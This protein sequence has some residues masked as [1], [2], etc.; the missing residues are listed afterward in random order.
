MKTNNQLAE[1]FAEI[2]IRKMEEMKSEKWEKPWFDVGGK[3]NFYPQN[4][5]GRKY[6]SG[7]AFLLLLAC[8]WE[9]YK[10]PLFL[11]FNQCRELEISI[12]KNEKSFPIYYKNFLVYH[13]ENNK[14]INIDNYNLLTDEKKKDWRLISYLKN[15]NVFNLDQ[16]NF[17]SV[18]E[19]EFNTLVDKFNSTENEFTV[20]TIF[21]CPQLDRMI[22]DK[23]WVCDIILKK[24]NRAYYSPSNDLIVCPVKNQ[25]PNHHNFYSVLLHEM[26]H[27]SS[28]EERLN[29][30]M[31]KVFGDSDYSREEVIAELTA[32]FVGTQLGVF[33]EPS[34]ES[35]TY[36]NGWIK[37]LKQSPDF[38][39]SVLDDVVKASNYIIEHVNMQNTSEI[40]QIRERERE[41]ER[42]II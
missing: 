19:D 31:G 7:N 27:S 9:G 4:Y 36:L 14:R 3:I 1:R 32:A 30:A 17:A 13:R 12:I 25:F 8:S 24:Q 29:R 22:E 37:I 23:S 6:T 18:Y 26:T 11:T 33:A 28:K 42:V 10:T 40:R 35:V 34:I 38:V 21:N 5:T 2:L 16:T 15:Y 41:I 39:F 20:D